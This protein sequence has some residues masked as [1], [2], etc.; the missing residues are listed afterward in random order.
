MLHILFSLLC[1]KYFF[2]FIE[3]FYSEQ[4]NVSE[5]ARI[6][7]LAGKITTVLKIAVDSVTRELFHS[8]DYFCQLLTRKENRLNL[9]VT[10]KKKSC[11]LQ[12]WYRIVRIVYAQRYPRKSSRLRP[13]RHRRFSNNYGLW[14]N[15]LQ[16]V[17][18][19]YVVVVSCCATD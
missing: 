15:R 16:G 10:L 17:N 19:S 14:C 8:R 3:M 13:L 6:T 7:S 11:C 12:L 2:W 18:K 1:V 4:N 9:I 5:R